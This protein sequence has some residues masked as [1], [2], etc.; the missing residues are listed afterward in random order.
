MRIAIIH[1]WLVG[2]RGGERVLEE[3]CRLY[4]EADIYTHVVAPNRLSPL[5]AERVIKT[6]GIA[7]LPMAQRLYKAYLPM[8]PRALEEIDLRGYDLVISSE[9][10]PS[11]GVIPPPTARHVCY[12]HTPMRYIWDHLH[13]YLKDLNPLSRAVFRRVAHKLRTW[14]VA[15]AARVDAFAANSS[16]VS[17]RIKRYWR[18]DAVVI[19]PP[20]DVAAYTPS[21]ERDD[22]YL[23]VSE[24]VPYKRADLVVEAFA[25]LD[26]RLVVVGDGPQAAKL[27]QLAGKNCDLRGRVPHEELAQLYAKCRALIFPGEEDFGIVPVEAMAAGRPVIA[28]ARGGARDTVVPNLSGL[29]FE[30]QTV[31]GLRAALTEF[32]AAEGAFDP[33]AIVAHAGSFNA[34]RFRERFSALVE[35]TLA[36]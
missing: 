12:T 30:E 25:G 28:Y 35:Q 15:S 8:M 32:E 16:F 31:E 13:E 27:R 18:R 11:K 7:K 24:L 17:A 5:L 6:S 10:G 1:Y 20:V 33:A 3:L 19:P 4:P 2:M 21:Q 9:S 22:Y 23:F 26:R 34:A 14:D 36:S 29:F